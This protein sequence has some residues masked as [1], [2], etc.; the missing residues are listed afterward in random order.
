MSIL[1]KTR[2]PHEYQRKRKCLEKALREKITIY[3][4]LRQAIL[5]RTP[6]SNRA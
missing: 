1:L 6:T 2:V 4:V 3:I 5:G